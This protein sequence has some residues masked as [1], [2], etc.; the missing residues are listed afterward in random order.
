MT[1][2][3]KSPPLVTIAIP[4]RNRGGSYLAH[5]LQS[6]VD[7]TYPELEILVCDNCSSDNTADLVKGFQHR[8]VRY[9][10]HDNNIGANENFNFGVMQARGDYFLL[11]HDDDLIDPDLVESCMTAVNFSKDAGI[12]RTGTRIINGSGE[13]KSEHYN[14]AGGLPLDDFFMAWFSGRTAFYLCSTLF[15]T[16]M[17][18]EIGGFHSSNNLYQDDVALVRLAAL[19]G[20]IDIRDI[21]AS[22][23]KHADEL[24]FSAKVGNWCDDSLELL[25][26]LCTLVPEKS[27]RAVMS[28]GM[29]F[30]SRANYGRANSVR[31]SAERFIAFLIVLRKF[32]FRYPPPPGYLLT[33]AS[34]LLNG[35]SLYR[36]LRRIKRRYRKQ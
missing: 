27:R 13:V 4:T 22:F 16:R 17:L 5:A 3:P 1:G 26:V 21:K 9:F 14:M 15:N 11:L 18:R 20:R 30:F 25:N 8:R 2:S 7:Q 35:T 12:I 19:S 29:K 10:R 28:E 6:A 24:G 36:T 31:S 33:F 32:G 34:R 23:R